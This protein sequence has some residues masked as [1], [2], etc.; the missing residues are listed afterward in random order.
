MLRGFGTYI[1]E[2]ICAIGVLLA[3]DALGLR[4]GITVIGLSLEKALV[5]FAM[6]FS[7]VLELI[8]LRYETN[9]AKWRESQKRG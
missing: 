5:Y 4:T 7:F 2:I 1:T 6:V 9:L 3:P 8:Q